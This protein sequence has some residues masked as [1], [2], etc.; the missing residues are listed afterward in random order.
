MMDISTN[1]AAL[2]PDPDPRPVHYTVISVDDHLVEPPHLFEG[3]VA[4]QFAD[5]AP[6]V[7]TVDGAATWAFD[8]KTYP[9]LGLNAVV[10]HRRRDDITF[11]PTGFDEMRR[12]C[13]EIEARIADMDIN[14]V[15]ASLNF[16]SMI[17]GFCGAVY[18]SAS[19]PE[20]GIAVA[21]AFNDWVAEEWWG[22]HPD[23]IIPL[24]ITYL[25]DPTVG[26]AEIRRNAAA[27]FRAVSLP[28]QPHRLGY[29]S[30]HSGWWDPVLQACEETGTVACL[31]VASSGNSFTAADAPKPATGATLFSA[32]S[33]AACADWLWSGVP[34]RF[35]SLKIALSEGG[36]G[37][38]PMLLD[39]LDYMMAH[40]GHGRSAVD[41][42][43][44]VAERGRG[45]QLLVLHLR[46]PFDHG[47]APSH[48]CRPDHDRGGLPARGLVVAGHAGDA[49]IGASWR[50]RRRGAPDHAP[51]RGG[52]VRPSAAGGLRAVSETP[53]VPGP[54]TLRRDVADLG[55]R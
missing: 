33:L 4:A 47:A 55:R 10:G 38:V 15:W 34:V 25:A 8:G 7:V 54:I 22:P 2:L 46:R 3:R 6:K 42:R 40:S 45:S 31:H 35:P 41:V 51:Q 53:D 13:F 36:I 29:P 39:R 26:A 12:G 48:R 37:W 27:G 20:L 44:P 21:R 17:S 28:E 52:A 19:D 23:R 32:L 24:G 30:L 18:S 50:A 5:L 11:E 9:Q 43:R 1:E 16:P 49:A 14:G